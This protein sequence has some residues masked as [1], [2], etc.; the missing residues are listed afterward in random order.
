MVCVENASEDWKK[1]KI[2]DVLVLGD[3]IDRKNVDLKQEMKSL[4]KLRTYFDDFNTHYAFGN[5]DLEKFGR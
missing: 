2:S 4:T 1:E 5:H 3:V